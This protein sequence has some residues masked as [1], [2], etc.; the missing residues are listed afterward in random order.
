MFIVVL[1][2]SIRS[3]AEALCFRVVQCP[4]VR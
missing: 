2:H 4:C 3:W 1:S